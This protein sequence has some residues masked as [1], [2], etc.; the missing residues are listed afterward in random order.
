MELD[1][2]NWYGSSGRE[3]TTNTKNLHIVKICLSRYIYIKEARLVSWGEA[4]TF[5][6]MVLR[7]NTIRE[8]SASDLFA[9]Y[10]VSFIGFSQSQN[11]SRDSAASDVG[12]SPTR[13]ARL[14]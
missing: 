6:T 5:Y 1:K 4:I 11:E 12:R 10:V 2:I 7:H 14:R 9:R 3:L 13:I 8:M